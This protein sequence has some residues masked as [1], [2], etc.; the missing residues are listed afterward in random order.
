MNPAREFATDIIRRLREAGYVGYIAGGAARDE[1]LGLIPKDYDVA[2]DCRPEQLMQLFPDAG[3]AQVGAHFGIVI[4]RREGLTVEVATFRSDGSYSDGR[5]PDQVTFENDPRQ[6]VLRRDFSINGLLLD[7]MTDQVIDHVGGLKDLADGVIR[8]I[9]NP[10]DRFREDHLRMLRAVRFAARF[11][12][13]IEPQ[14]MYAIQGMASE[15]RTVSV[16]RTRDE[17][18]R[19]LIEGGACKGLKLLYA[20]HLLD[21]ILPEM[22]ALRDCTQPPEFHPEGTVWQHV[23]KIL[24]EMGKPQSLEVALACL[25]HDI[26]KPATRTVDET[27]RIRFSGHAEI[28]SSMTREIL[29]RLKFPNAVIEQVSSMVLQHMKFHRATEM[30]RSTIKRLAQA[31][32]FPDYLELARLDS[33]G[34]RGDLTEYNYFRDRLAEMPPEVIRPER[35]LTGVD[36]INLGHKPGP[37]FKAALQAVEDAQLE[38]AITTKDEALAIALRVLEFGP[39]SLLGPT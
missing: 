33:L 13:M 14:T 7:P 34:A 18:S 27:G 12:F 19:I 5:R 23:L 24:G 20:A 22:L 4:V 39:Q 9:G 1:S 36:L 17:L 25:L 6:D 8:A 32:N 37:G 29:S 15:V 10:V 11:D 3:A 16:E 38:E 21:H 30:K 35:I 28:G 2:T 31:H 26:G